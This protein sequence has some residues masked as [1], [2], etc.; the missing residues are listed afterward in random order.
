MTEG[1]GVYTNLPE[2]LCSTAPYT[3]IPAPRALV[4]SSGLHRHLTN[5]WYS[6]IQTYTH[7]TSILK[8]KSDN[9]QLEPKERRRNNSAEI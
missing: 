7:K 6:L 5:T 4:T 1:L 9:K 8:K 2:G 3:V